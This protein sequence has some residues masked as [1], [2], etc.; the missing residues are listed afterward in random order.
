M[1]TLRSDMQKTTKECAVKQRKRIFLF[2]LIGS[3][4][5]TFLYFNC[6]VAFS[7]WNHISTR[8]DQLLYEFH[9]RNGL[10]AWETSTSTP[11][12]LVRILYCLK[13]FINDSFM[14]LN[15]VGWIT[16]Y[17]WLDSAFTLLVA[18]IISFALTSTLLSSGTWANK[19]F[20]NTL[21]NNNKTMQD[22]KFLLLK[23][24][25]SE[26]HRSESSL[27]AFYALR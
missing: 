4:G 1:A 22:R 21:E 26:V 10:S 6:C 9:M 25:E 20:L 3:S 11:P 13:S 16:L 24:A 23:I 15:S 18:I 2:P 19:F 27:S 12:P 8:K 17:V 5:V 7:D 14:R